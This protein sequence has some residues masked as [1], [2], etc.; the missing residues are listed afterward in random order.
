MDPY[1]I[2]IAIKA[3]QALK[4]SLDAAAL[5]ER[6]EAIDEAVGAVGRIWPTAS[7]LTSTPGSPTSRRR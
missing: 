1:S 2:G 4:K 5:Q 7:W 3:V 6:V